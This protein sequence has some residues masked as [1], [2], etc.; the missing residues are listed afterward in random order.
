MTITIRRAGVETLDAL[1]PL[2]DAYRVFY[3][4]ESDL[5]RARAF[6]GERL[7]AGDSVVFLAEKDGAPVGFTQLYPT[8][9]SV[10]TGRIFVLNDLYVGAGARRSGAGRA[11]LEAAADF[12]RSQGAVRLTLTTGRNNTVAQAAYEHLGWRRSDAFHTYNLAL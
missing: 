3:E 5:P 9:S 8:F 4:Q 11:L 12:G 2:F 6:M 1:A 10:S 7:A